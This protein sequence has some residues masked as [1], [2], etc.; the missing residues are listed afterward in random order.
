MLK[1]ASHLP[2]ENERWREE[3]RGAKSPAVQ[4]IIFLIPFSFSSVSTVPPLM[5]MVMAEPGRGNGT[6]RYPTPEASAQLLTARTLTECKRPTHTK[7]ET[8]TSTQ[9]QFNGTYFHK[10]YGTQIYISSLFLL[11]RHINSINSNLCRRQVFKP[12][13][14]WIHSKPTLPFSPCL[15]GYPSPL[16]VSWTSPFFSRHILDLISQTHRPNPSFFHFL[17]SSTIFEH[18][19]CSR[20]YYKRKKNASMNIARFL[21]S[22][23]PSGGDF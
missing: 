1:A 6:L 3:S 10:A 2:S 11:P 17:H 23:S 14:P 8:L 9:T 16:R 21:S 18:L 7:A 12:W 19:L 20:H 22:Q 15:N 13:K 4:G 5:T